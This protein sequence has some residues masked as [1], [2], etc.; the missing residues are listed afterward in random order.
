MGRRQKVQERIEQE[1]ADQQKIASAYRTGVAKT[2]IDLYNS[3][4]FSEKLMT[5]F[6]VAALVCKTHDELVEQHQALLNENNQLRFELQKLT[7]TLP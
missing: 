7:G 3:N 4:Q 6:A 2:L 1:Q 5:T